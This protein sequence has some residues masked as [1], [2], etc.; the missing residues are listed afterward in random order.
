MKPQTH[1]NFGHELPPV[2]RKEP[3]LWIQTF[4]EELLVINPNKS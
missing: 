2:T 1:L 3:R 4:A